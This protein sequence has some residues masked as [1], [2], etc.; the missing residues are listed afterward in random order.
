[1]HQSTVIELVILNRQNDARAFRKLVEAHQSMV[2]TLAFRLLCN[3]EDAKDVVQETFIRVWKHLDSFNTELKFSTWLYSIA[4]HR[5]YDILKKAKH[6]FSLRIEDQ[7]AIS[8]F[9]SNENIER[10]VINAELSHIISSL[11]KELT[12]K[13]KLVFTLCDL[14]GLETDEVKSITGLS[15]AKIKSNLYLARQFIRIKV[16]NL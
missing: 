5:C 6:N 16:Q 3:E 11:T 2:Y 13:Q 8:E 10:K 4:A 1:M 15:A 14:E 9:I 12:P 7:N